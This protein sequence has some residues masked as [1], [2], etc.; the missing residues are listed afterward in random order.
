[1]IDM[2]SKFPYINICIYAKVFFYC[3]PTGSLSSVDHGTSNIIIMEDPRKIAPVHVSSS[4]FN[5][6]MYLCFKVDWSVSL[7]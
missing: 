7:W 6:T 5:I 3:Q 4:M 2:L 1:M